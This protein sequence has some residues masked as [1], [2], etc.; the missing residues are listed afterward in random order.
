MYDYKIYQ[1]ALWSLNVSSI[2]EFSVPTRVYGVP[3]TDENRTIVSLALTTKKCPNATPQPLHR[4]IRGY[5]IY[6]LSEEDLR[7]N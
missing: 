5:C 7:R 1:H 3:L 4:L 6:S 2:C